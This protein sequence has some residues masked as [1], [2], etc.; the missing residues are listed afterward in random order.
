MIE[1]LINK[2]IE[3]SKL[4]HEEYKCLIENYKNE[5]I[6]SLV[7]EAARKTAKSA[8]G[9][10]VFLRGLVEISSFCKNDCYYCGIRS[11]NKSASRYRLSSDEILSCCREGYS[12]GIRSFVIQGGEDSHFTD[13]YLSSIIKAAKDEFPDAAIT[14]SLG[15][16]SYESYK[17]LKAAGVDRYLLRHETADSGHYKILHPAPLTLEKRVQCLK[18]LMEL[19]FQTGAGFMVGTKGQT[20]DTLASDMVFLSELQP[21]MVGIGPFI[22]H[23]ETPFKGCPAGSAELTKF[24]LSLTRLTLPHSLLP[25]TTALGTIEENG[26]EA[27][28]LSGA[29]VIML[30]LTPES[31]REEYSLYNNKNQTTAAEHSSIQDR[32]S[33]IGYNLVFTRGDYL[34]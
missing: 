31:R 4:E 10:K 29:N 15:E 2:L 20:S 25:S 22:P 30:S 33:E 23:N 27:G 11:S 1:Q 9:N 34:C 26:F 7:S 14:L 19:G 5:N 13:E 24:M 3:N 12:I 6:F 32:L 21:H 8:Y 18:N 16:R 17:M 28:I